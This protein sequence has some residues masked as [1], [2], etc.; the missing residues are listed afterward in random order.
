MG[1]ALAIA[2]LAEEIL[3]YV[4]L[5]LGGDPSQ[6]LAGT[7]LEQWRELW[8]HR[9]NPGGGRI[10]E[11]MQRLSPEIQKRFSAGFQLQATKPR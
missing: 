2:W 5:T 7:T 10:W 1:S 6:E 9:A 4:G 8:V 3:H 11:I